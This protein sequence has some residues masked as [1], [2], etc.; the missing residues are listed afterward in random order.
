M[1]D[2]TGFWEV[3]VTPGRGR[4]SGILT[5]V[6]Q[7]GTVDVSKAFLEACGRVSAIQAAFAGVGYEDGWS[8][9]AHA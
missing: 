4:Q 5:P 2:G 1:S 6:L 8:S 7:T 9:L 3:A